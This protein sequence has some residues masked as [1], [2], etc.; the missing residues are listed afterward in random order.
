MA[1]KDKIDLYKLHKD[2]YIKPKTP[3]LIKIHSAQYLS[4]T[5]KGE[6]GGKAFV[7]K[8]GALY[9]VAYTI[10]MRSKAAGQD[11]VVAKLEGLWWGSKKKHNFIDEPRETW[12]WKLLIRTPEFVTK[13]NISEAVDVLISKGKDETVREVTLEKINEGQCVQVLYIGGYDQETDTINAMTQYAVEKGLIPNG[14]HHEIYL[15]DPNKTDP[16]K[17]R[18]ILRQPVKKK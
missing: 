2:E 14:Y 11:Y 18:T 4:I 1:K 10:K 9:G 5:G 17:L 16:S 15:S 6:P 12:N 8:V 13:K 7:E 3:T